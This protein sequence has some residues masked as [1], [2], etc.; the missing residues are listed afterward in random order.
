[1]GV[2]TARE[3]DESARLTIQVGRRFTYRDRSSGELR[4]GYWDASTGLF[5]ATSQI[6]KTPT[7]LTHFPET[8]ES[9]RKLPGFSV[10]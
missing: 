6:R 1:V 8:W 7:I 5:T 4:V 10:E 3:Y 9:L 2:R